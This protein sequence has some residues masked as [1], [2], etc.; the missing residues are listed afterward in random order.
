VSVQFCGTEVAELL[1]EDFE[2]MLGAKR[3]C[4]GVEVDDDNVDEPKGDNGRF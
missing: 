3:D 2:G 4:G 1:Q